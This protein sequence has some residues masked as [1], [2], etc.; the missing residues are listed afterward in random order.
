MP[1]FATNPFEQDVGKCCSGPGLP[2]SPRKWVV[3]TPGTGKTK[4]KG[5]RGAAPLPPAR[6]APS[7]GPSGLDSASCP[8]GFGTRKR[9]A[10]LAKRRDGEEEPGTPWRLG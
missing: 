1:L 4:A 3:A 7:P 10:P 5:G 6:R 2:L 8:L 9:A